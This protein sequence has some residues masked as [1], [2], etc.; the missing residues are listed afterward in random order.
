MDFDN[1]IRTVERHCNN[2]FNPRNDPAALMRDYPPEFLVLVEQIQK[3]INEPMEKKTSVASETVIGLHQY[4]KATP[5]G[6]SAGWQQV[7]ASDLSQFKRA[8]FI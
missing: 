5:N 3:F 2:Y 7:F 4:S 1:L 8:R 6:V